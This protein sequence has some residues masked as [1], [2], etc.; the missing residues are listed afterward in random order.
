MQMI[1]MEIINKYMIPE[2]SFDISLD[3][4]GEVTFV[5]RHP[6]PDELKDW[7]VASFYLV[8]DNQILY[9]FPYRF[10]NNSSKGYIGLFDSMGAVD[11]CDVNDD[12]KDDVIIITYYVSGAGP[13]GMVPRPG[14]TIYL[15]G[16]NEFYLAEDM[17][18]NVENE[19]IEKVR[20]IENICDFLLLELVW[21]LLYILEEFLGVSL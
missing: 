1:P 14:V 4:W 20:T 13:T 12:K 11:F 2:Q 21:V 6:S 15:D 8:K 5:F 3:D 10:E 16:K 17:I 9:K 7:E 19:I 18:T